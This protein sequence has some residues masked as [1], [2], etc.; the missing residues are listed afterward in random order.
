MFSKI[1]EAQ[2]SLNQAY[3]DMAQGVIHNID[4]SVGD[5]GIPDGTRSA[6]FLITKDFKINPKVMTYKD[7]DYIDICFEGDSI[8][9][10][11][12]HIYHEKEMY[13]R[14]EYTDQWVLADYRFK[15]FN[16]K[17]MI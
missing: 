17:D 2:A 13:I 12:I 4:L 11:G 6:T 3:N 7:A 16:P 15:H 14:F 5:L 8:C 9:D 10:D 1:K